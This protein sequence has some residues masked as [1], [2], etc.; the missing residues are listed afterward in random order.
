MYK[1]L[2]ILG[3]STIQQTIQKLNRVFNLIIDG[4]DAGQVW[5]FACC[6]EKFIIYFL[7]P[8]VPW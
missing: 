5:S 3:F 7:F 1:C 2:L 6:G 8:V 4:I